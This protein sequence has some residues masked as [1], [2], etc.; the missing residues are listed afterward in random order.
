M[1]FHHFLVDHLWPTVLAP[2]PR[3]CLEIVSCCLLSRVDLLLIFCT[4]RYKRLFMPE[5][6]HVVQEIQKFNLPGEL[7]C[8]SS[9][10]QRRPLT[11]P[12]PSC[13]LDYRPRMEQFQKV[14]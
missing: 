7:G 2:H 1:V 13:V 9:A 14:S 5:P 6:Y 12:L 4:Y 11:N 3:L 8:A 10:L